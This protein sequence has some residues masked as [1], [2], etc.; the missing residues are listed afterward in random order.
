[1]WKRRQSGGTSYAREKGGG[2]HLA[3][4]G[5]AMRGNNRS[6]RRRGPRARSN[7]GEEGRGIPFPILPHPTT[8]AGACRSIA[9]AS[10]WLILSP[11][12]YLPQLRTTS[13]LNSPGRKESGRQWARRGPATAIEFESAF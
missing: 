13:T 10:A 7:G 8:R 5:G 2:L 6:S 11:A 1:M 4:S 3:G 9:I 12:T